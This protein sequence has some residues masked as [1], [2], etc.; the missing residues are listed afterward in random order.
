MPTAEYDW[1]TKKPSVVSL[2]KAIKEAVREGADF[3]QLIWGENQITL[4]K[5]A[6][7]SWTGPWVGNGWIGKNGGS[8]L[9]DELNKELKNAHD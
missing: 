9:A 1:K 8:D 6:H 4:E 2:K 5:L 7:S 3:I